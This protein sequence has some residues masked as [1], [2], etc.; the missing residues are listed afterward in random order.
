VVRGDFNL[1]LTDQFVSASGLLVEDDE[2]MIQPTLTL[3]TPLF[4]DP[5]GWLQTVTLTAG[6]WANWS[7]EEG[8]IDPARWREMDTFAGLTLTA[9]RRWRLTGVY[10]LYDSLTGSFST[11]SDLALGVV[12]DDTDWLGSAALHPFLEWRWQTSGSTTQPVPDLPPGEGWICKVG[13]TPQWSTDWGRLEFPVFA[14]FVSDGFYYDF[15][16]AA[17]AWQAASGGAAFFSAAIKL[18][19]PVPWLSKGRLQTQAYASVQYHHLASDALMETSRALGNDG[20][21]DF[22]QFHAGLR[23]S[24]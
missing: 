10:T 23:I 14:A 20:R 12:F 16:E 8:G 5:A 13:V 9:D 4:T 17:G 22:V 11:A 2:L 24:F 19:R 3:Y 6:F 7:S 15:N 21:R 1:N 18:S